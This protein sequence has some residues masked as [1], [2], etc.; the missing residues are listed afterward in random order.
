MEIVIGIT[1][2]AAG[3]TAVAVWRTYF[4]QKRQEE[5]SLKRDVLKRI[6]GNRF[7]L[8]GKI[9]C[10]SAT[11]EP[12]VALN[13]ACVVYHDDADA[14]QALEAFHGGLDDAKLGRDLPKLI[15]ALSESAKVNHLGLG[16][17]FTN[18]PFT[19]SESA[20]NNSIIFRKKY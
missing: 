9:D 6:V 16:D 11:G 19:P 8:T 5:L 17:Y 1:A 7:Y 4:I 12:F 10:M 2:G 20:L 14:L 18:R 3:A 13:E 15:R